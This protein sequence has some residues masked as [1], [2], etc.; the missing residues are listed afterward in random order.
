MRRRPV[1]ARAPLF[2]KYKVA[3]LRF[4]QSGLLNV[5]DTGGFDQWVVRS[6]RANSAGNPSI[7]DPGILPEGW[8]LLAPL[9]QNAY[10]LGSKITVQWLPNTVSSAGVPWVEKS[11]VNLDGQLSPALDEVLA[12]KYVRYGLYGAGDGMSAITKKTYSFSTKRWF[13]VKD[14]KDNEDLSQV[15]VPD[16]ILPIPAEREAFWNVGWASTFPTTAG[17]NP[18]P[19]FVIIDY[20]VLFCGPRNVS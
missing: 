4:C 6:F 5:T 16:Q 1:I 19:Y 9:F 14:V 10:T 7:S 18:M 17:T 12:N 20:I 8:G 2:G 15:I 3:K 13:N 11:T